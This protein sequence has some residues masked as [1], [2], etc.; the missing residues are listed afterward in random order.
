M[1]YLGA[2]P[3]GELVGTRLMPD[4]S[5]KSVRDILKWSEEEGVKVKVR[6]SGYV[7]GQK[8]LPGDTIKEGMVCSIEFNQNI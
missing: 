3:N 6:G 5:G 1:F 7:T 4:L 2:S 8:P